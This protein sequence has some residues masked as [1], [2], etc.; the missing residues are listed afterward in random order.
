LSERFNKAAHKYLFFLER[1]KRQRLTCL[2]CGD[3]VED[4]EHRMFTLRSEGRWPHED[5]WL[6]CQ[7]CADEKFRRRLAHTPAR[8]FPSGHGCPLEHSNSD[9]TGPWG[10]NAIR[11]LEDA[12][13]GPA[14]EAT[15]P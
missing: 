12:N 15:G 6:Y 13:E 8:T 5:E 3:P 4:K 2:A 11:H 14:G 9:D 1:E 7:E 10:E